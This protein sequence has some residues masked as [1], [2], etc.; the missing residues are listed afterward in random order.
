MK[1]S[2]QSA[3]YGAAQHAAKPRASAVPALVVFVLGMMCL[4][5]CSS[6]PELTHTGF[7]SDYSQLRVVNDSKMRFESPAAARYDRFIVDPVRVEL[8]GDSL[9]SA[10]RSEAMRHFNTKLREA[11]QSS[12][13][14]VVTTPGPGVARVRVALTGVTKSTWWQ[15][16]HPASRM[17]GAGTGG[18]AMEAEVVDSV[19]GEQIGAVVQAGSGNQ[20]DFTSFSTLADVKS[21]ID[22][23]TKV[24]ADRLREIRA[25]SSR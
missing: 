14:T 25:P 15:K 4:G 21:A 13:H 9:S 5:G 7:L 12:G 22:G 23:W 20:F 19:T 16:V 2:L 1:V 24:F 6:K 10:D 3:V 18:A 11:V 17:A 8:Q